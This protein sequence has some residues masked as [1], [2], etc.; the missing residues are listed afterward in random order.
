MRNSGGGLKVRI[1]VCTHVY[2]CV[3]VCV[4]V[5]Y[6]LI[7]PT[8]PTLIRGAEGSIQQ[9]IRHKSLLTSG[10]NVSEC[11]EMK[12][13]YVTFRAPPP[14]SFACG[15]LRCLLRSCVFQ[16][17]FLFI[18]LPLKRLPPRCFHCQLPSDFGAMKV[19]KMC[20]KPSSSPAALECCGS[21]EVLPAVTA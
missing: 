8:R 15:L 6:I 12:G 5:S 7:D 3:S 20:L 18:L 14:P 4:C 1:Y 16:S 21:D 19:R 11:Y 2:P 17:A 13:S 10:F 9:W